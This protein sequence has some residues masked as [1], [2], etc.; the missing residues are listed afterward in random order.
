VLAVLV[1]GGLATTVPAGARGR[2]AAAHQRKPLS[3]MAARRDG[4]TRAL[5][6]GRITP[7]RYALERA[8]ALFDI[9]QV[10]GRF[11]R[12]ATPHRREATLTLRDLNLR[13]DGLRPAQRRTA[14]AILARPDGGANFFGS[15]YKNAPQDVR[16]LGSVELCFHWAL[17]GK[18][19]PTQ[20][21]GDGDGIPN[22]VETTI[23]EFIVVWNKET[24]TLNYRKPKNDGTSRY[25]GPNGKTDIYLADLGSAGIYGYCSSDDPNAGRLGTKKYPYWDVS[26][27]CVVDEDFSKK[28]FPNL[29]PL[30]NL[31]VTAAHEFFH[32]IQF[33]YDYDE[34]AWLIEGTATALEDQVFDGVDDNYQYLS[35]SQLT[36]PAVPVDYS[37]NDQ[38]SNQFLYRY[39]AWIFWRHMTEYFGQPGQADP[40]VIRDVWQ[41]ADASRRRKY[42][43]M[44]SLQAAAATSR[45]HGT[46]FRNLFADYGVDN[47]IA[48]GFYEEGAGYLNYVNNNCSFA[49]SGCKSSDGGRAPFTRRFTVTGLNPST[50][51]VSTKIDHLAHKYVR[52]APGDGV[53]SADQLRVKTNGPE[54]TSGP[55]I[56]VIVFDILGNPTV[57]SLNLDTNGNGTLTV[58]FGDTSSVVLVMTNASTDNQCFKFEY[59]TSCQGIPQDDDKPF[60]YSATLAP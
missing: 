60:T 18:H 25:H 1:L 45:A 5:T 37:S 24:G 57:Y 16:C 31:R 21:D 54:A 30:K 49:G 28:E 4:L 8:I 34:D 42:G 10:R 29:T 36:H 35:A 6:T 2:S 14:E 43:D 20:K 44:Y 40:L 41:R 32:A 19:A 12:V 46:L 15:S 33:A 52:Y 51:K 39:G 22:W 7:S 23:R 38:F 59:T 58:P 9:D 11:G 26:A 3:K 50:P 53:N 56:K 48:D 55:R 17:S 47:F 27:F 13:L